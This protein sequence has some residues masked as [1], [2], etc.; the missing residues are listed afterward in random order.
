MKFTDDILQ[1]V[2][3]FGMDGYSLFRIAR[4]LNLTF[5]ELQ[6]LRAKNE[7][8]NDALNRAELNYDQYLINEYEKK[9]VGLKSPV[10]LE[11]LKLL[12]QKHNTNLDNEIIIRRV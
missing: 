4:E 6:D 5:D 11:L 12:K 10:Q 9:S 1:S 7:K 8:L 3:R 2:V